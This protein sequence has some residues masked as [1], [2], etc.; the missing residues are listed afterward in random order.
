MRC[1]ALLA[2]AVP[3][4]SAFAFQ[5]EA[6]TR[7]AEAR[8]ELFAN[9]Y[10]KA[11][12]LYSALV[13][14]EPE[15]AD[16][17]Y[18][19]VRALLGAHRAPEAY[20]YADQALEHAPKSGSAENAA[21]LTSFRKGDLVRAE[22]HF[23]AALKLNSDDPAG[24]Q[25]LASIYSVLSKFKT[26]RMLLLKAY[27]ISPDD[28]SLRVAYA[29]SLKGA[30]HVEALERIL[31]SL[32]RDSEEAKRLRFHIAFEKAAPGREL[33][34]LS[35]P[36][37]ATQIKLFK[38]M[39]GFPYPSGLTVSVQLNQK[40]TLKL[41]VDASLSGISIGP[42]AA[43]SAGL[44][45]VGEGIDVKGEGVQKPEIASGYLASEVRIG[46][47]TFADCPIEVFR[48]AG[49]G[50]FDGSIGMELFR[51][52]IV[53]IDIPGQSLSLVARPEG[54]G[55][56]QEPT[57]ASDV[58]P[59]GFVRL[60]R[61]GSAVAL[62]TSLNDHP[63]ALFLLSTGSN[64]NVIDS[65]LAHRLSL[66][67]RD[68]RARVT[69]GQGQIPNIY[70]ANNMTLTFAGYRHRNASL[71]GL[72]LHNTREQIGMELGGSLGMP[73]LYELKITVDYREGII[74]TEYVP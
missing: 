73:V 23:R 30:E 66:F 40:L 24:L 19:L 5:S 13:S 45:P 56:P 42:G 69:G 20:R 38:S 57:D 25:G 12:D 51:Q 22:A 60:L 16:A 61:F 15:N 43:K 36:Y 49:N 35:S 67:Y 27:S 68:D 47:V 29:D 10:S 52:F 70:R 64:T 21:G 28:P 31:A 26:A 54:P 1:A 34:R 50:P 4:A 74:R 55:D 65:G 2:M 39:T 33:R 71:I 14:R 58:V 41:R 8:K 9:R 17:Y 11:A 3:L 32:D 18:G 46:N 44:I 37:A 62:S 6:S 59:A 7:L 53:S 63:P 72:D 48:G